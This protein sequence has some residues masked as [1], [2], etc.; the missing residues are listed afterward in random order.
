MSWGYAQTRS[1]FPIDVAPEPHRTHHEIGSIMH[2][3]T[4]PKVGKELKQRAHCRACHVEAQ[5]I[6]DQTLR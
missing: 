1:R 5:G 4:G 6:P 3:M 2:E